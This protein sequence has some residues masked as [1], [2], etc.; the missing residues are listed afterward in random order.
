MNIDIPDAVTKRSI[1]S[2]THK[3][4][5]PIGFTCPITLQPKFISA[6][7]WSEKTNWDDHVDKKHSEKFINWLKE[8]PQLKNIKIPRSL[9]H[10]ELS[11]HVFADAS[12]LSYA[13]VVFARTKFGNMININLLSAKSRLAPK[14][15][16]ISRL[17]LMAAIIAVRLKKLAMESLT[18][19]VKQVKFWSDSTTVLAWIKR[20]LSYGTFVWN[21]VKEIRLLSRTDDW[22]YVPGELNP[23]DLPSRGCSPRELVNS[24]WWLGPEWLYKEENWPNLSPQVNEIEF[25]KEIKKTA[26]T[27]MVNVNSEFEFSNYFLSYN[28]LLR[29]LS[30]TRRFFNNCKPKYIEKRN[31]KMIGTLITSSLDKLDKKEEEELYLT[32]EEIKNTEILLLKY[33]QTQMFTNKENNSLSSLKTFTNKDGLRVLKTKILNRDD[34][35]MFLCPIILK[36]NHEIIPMIVRDMHERLGHTGCQSIMSALREKFWITSLRKT[37]KRII[38]ECVVCKRQKA[39]RME[40]ESTPLPLNRVRDALVFEVTGVDFAGPVYIK[41][42]EKGWICIFTCAVYRAVHL[43]LASSL[44][45]EGFIHCL[46]RFIARRS[47]PK[48]LYSDNGTNFT[49]TASAFNQ[50]DWERILKYTSVSQIEWQFNPPSAPWWGGWWE[51]RIGVLKTIL[52]KV[53][54]KANLSYENLTTALCNAEAIIN[55]RPLTY[56]S[57]DREDFKA[58]T[59]SMFLQEIPVIGV[60]DCDML[61][62]HKLNKKLFD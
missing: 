9:G 24:K 53:L 43:E 11:L 30:W 15:T 17:E 56:I 3:V 13:A 23:A 32:F 55:A 57:E 28:K 7:L 38:S 21:R 51:R 54:G 50:L 39:K 2:A 22:N 49:G 34:S 29:F 45:V 5:N 14:N 62:N 52:R 37:I 41:G 10:G 16:T 35:L 58:L 36:S 59:P 31:L 61:Y 18:R 48:F 60:P 26:C 25:K 44:S 19:V 6:Q 1:L 42:G 40:C 20:D 4:F 8:L 33:L 12:G 47:R 27:S 46:R